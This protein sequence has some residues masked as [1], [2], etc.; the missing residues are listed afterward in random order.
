VGL[1][2]I[3][4]ATAKEVASAIKKQGGP[5]FAADGTID[6]INPEV[7]VYMGAFYL[8]QLTDSMGS[9]ML[10]LLAYNGGPGRIRRLRRQSASLPEDIFLETIDITETRDYGKRVMAAAAAYGYL[11]YGM[12]M[13]QVVA[14]IFK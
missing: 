13:D 7:N 6:L 4:P 5:D 3:M 10:A 12:S 8:R 11:Y 1:A 14:D 9:P 2:Q